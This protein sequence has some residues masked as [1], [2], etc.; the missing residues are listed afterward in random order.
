M[1]SLV[2]LKS[3]GLEL[4]DSQVD[5][6]SIIMMKER[7]DFQNNLMFAGLILL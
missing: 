5:S 6:Q 2:L 3:I 7:E 1:D 4:L